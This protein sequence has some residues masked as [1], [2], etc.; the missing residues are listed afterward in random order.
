MLEE[1][2]DCPK[3]LDGSFQYESLD[4]RS[5]PI[6]ELLSDDALIHELRDVDMEVE[7]CSKIDIIFP[8]PNCYNNK[9]KH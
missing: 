4:I 6:R 3:K 5:F 7:Y 1:S 9:R 8:S 2:V